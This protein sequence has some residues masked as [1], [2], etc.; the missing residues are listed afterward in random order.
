MLLDMTTKFIIFLVIALANASLQWQYSIFALEIS[1]WPGNGYTDEELLTLQ[2]LP[3]QSW[4]S[5]HVPPCPAFIGAG[6]QG[7]MSANW[8]RS[9]AFCIIV[10][11]VLGMGGGALGKQGL[12]QKN[13]H[14]Y[15]LS[16]GI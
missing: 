9:P 10:H 3:S 16:E 12:P 4:H 2:C 15:P 14:A 8:V 1:V 7:I 11:L 6:T 13:I 5:M